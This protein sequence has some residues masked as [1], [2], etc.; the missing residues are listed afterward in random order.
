MSRKDLLVMFAGFA[1]GAVLASAVIVQQY[2][3]FSRLEL[4]NLYLSALKQQEN[5]LRLI[6]IG[7]I[8]EATRLSERWLAHCRSAVSNLGGRVDSGGIAPS[9]VRP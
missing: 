5:Q 3:K 4:I 8:G 2:A 6:S 7:D 9:G 1:M